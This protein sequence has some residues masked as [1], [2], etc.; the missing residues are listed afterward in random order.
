MPQFFVPVLQILVGD[1]TVSVE[2]KDAHMSAKVVGWVQLVEGVLAGR[3][4]HVY[5]HVLAVDLCIVSVHRESVGRRSPLLVVIH[6]ESL[7]QFRFSDG[8]VSQQD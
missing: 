6:E 1:S 2:D 3:V 8:R 4:P 7:N 5:F